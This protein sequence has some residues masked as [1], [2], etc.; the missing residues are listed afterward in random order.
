MQPNEIR[1]A[2][3]SGNYNGVRDG[4][5]RALNTLVGYLLKQGVQVRVYSPTVDEPAFEPT[6]DLVSLPSIPIPGRSEYR[7]SLGLPPR[8]RRDLAEFAPNIVHIS[9]PDI[10]GHRAVSWARARG[11]PVVA[12]V[13][14]RFD[15]YL[16]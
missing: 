5:N 11:I 15:T 6:G 12:S 7:L 4:A 8:V 9:A 2:L 10:G 1:V 13:H 14:T 3:V 16:A